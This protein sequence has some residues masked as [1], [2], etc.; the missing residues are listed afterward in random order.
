MGGGGGGVVAAGGGGAGGGG[1]GGGGAGMAAAGGGGG[2][3]ALSTGA[4]GVAIPVRVLFNL[5]ISPRVPT[6]ALEV[7]D[8]WF[9]VA[10]AALGRVTDDWFAVVGAL[11]HPSPIREV[12]VNPLVPMF[13]RCSLLA[14]KFGS[15][16]NIS[17]TLAP[18]S[19]LAETLEATSAAFRS[20]NALAAALAAAASWACT[21]SVAARP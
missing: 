3:A 16:S 14:S 1:V 17:L 10:G 13:N 21:A 6:T 2:G 7:T 15:W 19:A 4:S 8:D 12:G 20:A 18:C 9:A 5:K 11:R